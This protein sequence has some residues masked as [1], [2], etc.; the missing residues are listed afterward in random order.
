VV[1]GSSDQTVQAWDVETGKLQRTVE[2]YGTNSDASVALQV[3]SVKGQWVMFK[4]DGL[5]LLPFQ[6][7]ITC[8]AVY[9]NTVALDFTSGRVLVFTCK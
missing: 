8:S 5:L 6:Y 2:G 4:T 9:K 7:E 3:I 1:S